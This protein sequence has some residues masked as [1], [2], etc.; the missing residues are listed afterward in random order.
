[1]SYSHF[2][3]T[4]RLSLSILLNRGHSQE[5]I[6]YALK[7]N[8]SSISREIKQNSVGTIYDPYKAD[9]KAYVKRHYSKFIGMKIRNDSKLEQRVTDNISHYWTPEE[10][11]GRLKTENNDQTVISFKSIYKYLYSP[12]GQYLCK[13]LP[14]RHYRPIQHRKKP[15]S[16]RSLIPNKTP[17]KSRPLAVSERLVFGHFEADTLGAIRSDPNRIIGLEERLSRFV[18]ASKVSR[19]KY[20][21]DGFKKS[22]NPYHDILGSVTFDNGVEN[23]RHQELGVPTYFCNPYHS[24]EKGQIENSFLRLRRFIPKKSH[25]K[26]FP[27]KLIA[28]FINLMNNTPRKILNYRTPSEVFNEH[29]SRHRSLAKL[30][31]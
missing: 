21:M 18:I 11:A 20:S 12:Y 30:L 29:L 5:D 3:R 2:T 13:F 26:N 17:I 16:S 22:L 28:N 15:K 25:L 31:S 4:D 1:M 27:N 8:P 24:W 14:S 23:V 9:H 6:A 19:L 10:I 7:K